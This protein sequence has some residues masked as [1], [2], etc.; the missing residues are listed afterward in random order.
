MSDP[1]K[2][3]IDGREF[4]TQ[5]G[6]MIIQV[7]DDAGIDIPRFCYH[8]KLSIAANCRMCLV[9]VEK[10]PKPLPAC[11]TPVADG[12]KIFT[13][14]DYAMDAQKATMEFLLINHP[15]DCPICDQ[16]GECPLQD[17]AMAYGNDV[18]RFAEKKR[19]V[20]DQDIGPL[21][22]T[23]MTR[24]IH[25]TRCVRFGQE[26]AGIMELGAT[27]RG[28]HMQIGAYIE[29][30]V[31]SELSG[32]AIDLCPVGALTS[33]P[34]RFSARAW[35]LVN[36]DSI[37]PHDCVGANLSIQTLRDEVKRV[38]PRTNEAINECWIADRD[39]YSYEGVNSDERLTVPM[40][41]KDDEWQETDWQSA[42]NFAVDGLHGVIEKHG[43]ESIGAL[44][45]PIATTE[46][47]YLLQKLYRALGSGNID[48]RLRQI[49]FSDDELVPMFPGLEISIAKIETRKAILLV[50]SNIR[51]DQ[52]L[53]G[54][55][56]RKAAL[57]GAEVLTINPLN[58][59]FHF[60]MS[61]KS[62]VASS[63][64]VV[65]LAR[66]AVALAK[67]NNVDIPEEIFAWVDD[68]DAAEAETAIASTLAEQGGDAIIL[69]GSI[70]HQ[71]QDLAALK[72]ISQWISDTCGAKLGFLADANS[73]GAH[74]AGCVPHHG[75]HGSQD[76]VKGKSA[77]AL[78]DSSCKGYLLFGAEPEMDCTRGAAANKAM[79][80]AEFVV[81]VSAFRGNTDFADVLLPMTPFTETSGT[82][83]NCEG[84]AQSFQAAVTPRGESRPGWKILR[85]LGN[86]FECDGFDQVSSQDVLAEIGL[87]EQHTVS[88]RSQDLKIP[89][90]SV[91][92]N[93]GEVERIVDTPL[94]TIDPIVRRSAP[95]QATKDNPPAALRASSE[96]LAKLNLSVESTTLVQV[97]G[98]LVQL[99]VVADERVPSGSVYIP[100]GYEKTRDLDGAVSVK[101]TSAS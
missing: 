49:D 40:I 68:V 57:A 21:I 64:L 86:L 39:R 72:A 58:Y 41:R 3:E 29:Q 24:C 67:A 43:A 23:E 27:G 42:L 44:A 26:V 1:I 5:P 81:S 60:K 100:A 13:H 99:D 12:M 48:H 25:C 76:V 91:S 2:V 89:S 96:S 18:S 78:L 6:T 20:D 11:A 19:V 77:D 59:D 14:S 101:V 47:F 75:V 62:I 82:F 50:G 61:A 17:Q 10:A 35:E 74:L 46:E 63:Q 69:L 36:H 83:V 79:T 9:Q 54:L 65:S 95:L 88:L 71:H 34:C 70:A 16:G 30:T 32:N 7:A 51:K 93:D 92:K 31:D 37:S 55:R 66:V 97:N 22:A 52:P 84:K 85:V 90:P 45:S 15:L 53:L 87:Q 4:E 73:A 28:E 56:V 94:Y 80:E 33:K 98:H 8:K 38:L